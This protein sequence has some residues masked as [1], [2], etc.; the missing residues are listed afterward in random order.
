ME[1]KAAEQKEMEGDVEDQL[2]AEAKRAAAAESKQAEVRE[3]LIKIYKKYAPG[4]VD[5]VPALLKTYKGREDEILEK[6]KKKYVVTNSGTKR[7]PSVTGRTR[8]RAMPK[9][10]RRRAKAK[11]T[12]RAKEKSMLWEVFRSRRNA[13]R[14]PEACNGKTHGRTHT[15][16]QQGCKRSRYM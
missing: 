11:K 16:A 10:K 14:S 4:R 9:R 6:V 3:E 13:I 7:R 1:N 5:K 12:V 8:K 15:P 2:E